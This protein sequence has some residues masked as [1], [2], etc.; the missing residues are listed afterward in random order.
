MTD[1]EACEPPEPRPPRKGNRITLI[2][3]P[4]MRFGQGTVTDPEVR[5][6]RPPGGSTGRTVTSRCARLTCDCGQVYLATLSSLFRG[7]RK[8][9]GCRKKGGPG[10]KQVY[11]QSNKGGYAV[12]AYL[13]W[14]K[15]KAE[16]EEIA[17]R[18]RVMVMP[19]SP[20]TGV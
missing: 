5:V 8:S 4:G 18:T 7:Q 6:P 16:A 17:R 14:T 12:V 9:C 19:E 11:F 3:V 2:A 10:L 15:T 1:C 13:G 20:I